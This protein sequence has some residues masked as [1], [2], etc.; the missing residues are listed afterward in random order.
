MAGEELRQLRREMKYGVA[1][2]YRILGLPRRTYQDYEAGK[3][4]IPQRVA[5]A[6]RAAHRRDREFMAGL[7]GRIHA[8]LDRQFPGGM[9]PAG[10]EKEDP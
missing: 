3:R 6:A 1:D 9:I 8:C 2:M 10:A 4:G 7:P 5:V